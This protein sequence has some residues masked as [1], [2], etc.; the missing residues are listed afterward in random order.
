MFN[1]NNDN[2][3]LSLESL[4]IL[5]KASNVDFM[6]VDLF[7]DFYQSLNLLIF[8]TY[9]DDE[10]YSDDDKI[11]HFNWCWFK[12]ISNFKDEGIV[13]STNEE[14]Y[15]YFLN[16]KIDFYYSLDKENCRDEIELS[17]IVLTESILSHNK[18]KTNKELEIFLKI[19]KLLKKSINSDE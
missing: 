14:I 9:L 15:D 6:L 19:Y 12:N 2:N 13:F 8:E 1:I 4:N 10:N 7:N 11:K 17:I 16:N 3:I 5:Y 18:K